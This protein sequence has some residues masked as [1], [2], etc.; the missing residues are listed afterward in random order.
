[1]V[2]SA[3]NKLLLALVFDKADYVPI[4]TTPDVRVLAFTFALSCGAAF[5]FGLLPA[6]RMPSEIARTIRGARFRWGKA[7]IVGEVAVSLVVLV[8]AGVFSR[9]L[10]NLTGQQFGFDRT[11]VL[12]ISVDPSLA[13]YEYNRLRPLYQQLASR[14][15]AL[16]GVEKA[17]FSYYSPFNGCC[18]AFSVSV[19]GYTPKARENMV[20]QLNRVSPHYFE[21]LATKVLHGRTFDERDGPTAGRVAVVTDAFAQRYFPN[22]DPIGRSFT[23]DSEGHN[24]D[25]E[26]IGVVENTKYSSPRE[27]PRPMAFLPLL[28][29]RAN[30]SASSGN[31]QSNFINAIEVRSSGDPMLVAGLV[32]RTL[33]EIAP[34][35]PVLRVDT[36]SEQI[37]GTV[38]QERAI[39]R[40]AV[41]FGSLALVLTCVGLYGLMAYLV[42]RRT[43]EIGIRIAL[44][45]PRGAVIRM[46]MREA[47]EQ[48]VVG[49]LVG[50]PMAFAVT[51]LIAS[52]LYD[53]S[54][55]NPT[56]AATAALV[57]IVGV[58]L[59][60]YAP[61][62]RASRT[63]PIRALRQE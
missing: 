7:L 19:P 63:D 34:D 55:S 53:V 30:E 50:M 56:Y 37:G 17:S 51:Q 3:A 27:Q 62:Y 1:L 39:A 15:N 31:Y 29:V 23:I 5:V 47:L 28:Q 9:S 57:L 10:A 43:K 59:A 54:P 32:Q 60:G 35:L 25:R 41:L 61:A 14:L 42:Q 40:L 26:I 38:S 46:V 21:T 24:A 8:G 11:R 49:I 44:G 48:V 2:A 13:R 12:V 6:I 4:Q 20:A 16:P 36:L 22:E 33:A 58:T 52:Q 45:V 18:W